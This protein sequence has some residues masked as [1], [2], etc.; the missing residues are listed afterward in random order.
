MNVATR[1]KFTRLDS[2]ERPEKMKDY[3]DKQG[4]AIALIYNHLKN[5]HRRQICKCETVYKI[6][7]KLDAEYQ[8]NSKTGVMSIT[9]KWQNLRFNKGGDLC[10]YV[11]KHEYYAEQLMETGEDLLDDHRVYQLHTSL[12]PKYDNAMEY[13]EG[14]DEFE[15]GFKTYDVY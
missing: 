6:M 12:P 14:L 11:E 4:Q 10:K 15:D 5:T 3:F 1:K 8:V 13:Y 2:D 7:T 9:A